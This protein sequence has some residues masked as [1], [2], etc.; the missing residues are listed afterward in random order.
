MVLTVI[1][2][3][4][5]KPHGFVSLLFNDGRRVLCRGS[6]STEPPDAIAARC[7]ARGESIAFDSGQ[8]TDDLLRPLKEHYEKYR[9][10]QD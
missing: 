5:I 6:F 2:L 10:R 8:D 9:D 7:I 3:E 1:A 4:D